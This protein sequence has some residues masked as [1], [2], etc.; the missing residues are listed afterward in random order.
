[1]KREH[2]YTYKNL[3]KV[4]PLAMIDDL[5]GM[6]SCGIQSRDLNIAINSEIEMK[7]L[8]FHVPDKSGK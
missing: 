4:M 6:A 8:R 7:K 2:L 1:M 5:L 3:V